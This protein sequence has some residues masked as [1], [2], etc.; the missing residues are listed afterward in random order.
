[1]SPAAVCSQKDISAA[2]EYIRLTSASL[3][4]LASDHTPNNSSKHYPDLLK[5]HHA[6]FI[7]SVL[8]HMHLWT[9][10]AA[11]FAY[12]T[13]NILQR[14]GFGDKDYCKI[15]IIIFLCNSSLFGFCDFIKVHSRPER[16]ARCNLFVF[17]HTQGITKS[18]V[19]CQYR[20][21]YSNS[22]VQNEFF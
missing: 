10:L 14:W 15:S 3:W 22:S 6:C 12:E 11:D 5:I 16:S 8:P 17:N 4:L 19:A 7:S 13:G 9:Q 1:M 18:E 20:Q 2:G 21:S